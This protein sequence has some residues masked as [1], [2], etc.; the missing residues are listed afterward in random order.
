MK[1]NE[2]EKQKFHDLLG[3]S[4]SVADMESMTV[5]C[6]IADACSSEIKKNFKEFVEKKGDLTHS[7]FSNMILTV[8]GMICSK[9]IYKLHEHG[10]MP[11]SESLNIFSNKISHALEC[12]EVQKD[13]PELFKDH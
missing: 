6:K 8:L 5:I 12:E 10:V 9:E 4:R 7:H 11:L 2:N 3:K 1:L 13:N